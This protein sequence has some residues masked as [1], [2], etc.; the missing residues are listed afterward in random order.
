MAA[1]A[2]PFAIVF[3]PL[4]AP[5]LSGRAAL[6]PG[7]ISTADAPAHVGE[8]VT[9]EG[10]VEEVHVARNGSA[11]FL[12]FDGV[13]PFQPF[14]AVIFDQSRVG[15]VSDLQDRTVAVTGTIRLYHDRPEIVV[16]SRDQLT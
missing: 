3:F 1:I 14:A 2:L 12:D 4:A 16:D 15:D 5:A 10:V 13:Y 9:V 6:E 8:R 11:T 7:A